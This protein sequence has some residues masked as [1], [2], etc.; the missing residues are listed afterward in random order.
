MAR[1]PET[2][3]GEYEP[4][5]IVDPWGFFARTLPASLH[6]QLV[7]RQTAAVPERAAA[8]RR[9]ERGYRTRNPLRRRGME[10]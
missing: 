3:A 1:E 4:P 6:A 5:E 7:T 10:G 2:P 8:Q 9:A